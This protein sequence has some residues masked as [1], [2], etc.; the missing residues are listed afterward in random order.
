MT[1][2]SLP[3]SVCPSKY[4]PPTDHLMFGDINKRATLH[5]LQASVMFMFTGESEKDWTTAALKEARLG[6]GLFTL[7]RIWSMVLALQNCIWTK[8]KFRNNMLWID[9]IKVAM[10]GHHASPSTRENITTKTSYQQTSMMME[11]WLFG[12]ALQPKDLGNVQ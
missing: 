7:K 10:F 4:T 5:D 11:G 1:A 6:K 3:R 9:E 8:Y 12:L 2:V